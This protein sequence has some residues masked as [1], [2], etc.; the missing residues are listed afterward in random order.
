M[1]RASVSIGPPA[2]NGTTIVI[3]RDGKVWA[4]AGHEPVIASAAAKAAALIKLRL[5]IS[6][7]TDCDRTVSHPIISLPIR[8]IGSRFCRCGRPRG[9]AMVGPAQRTF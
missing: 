3:G 5:V 1:T 6:A 7:A 4:V 2:A 8:L 9:R